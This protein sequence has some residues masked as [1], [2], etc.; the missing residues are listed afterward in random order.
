MNE[1]N[2]INI[3]IIGIIGFPDGFECEVATSEFKFKLYG[4][5][6]LSS[7]FLSIIFLIES[8]VDCKQ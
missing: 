6:F 2:E 7:S 4:L 5:L 1:E 3:K 8:L